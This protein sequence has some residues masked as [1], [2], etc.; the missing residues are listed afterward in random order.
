MVIGFVE[1]NEFK[2][3]D[4]ISAGYASKYVLGNQIGLTL[5]AVNPY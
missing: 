2:I 5:D 3:F 1:L 4:L